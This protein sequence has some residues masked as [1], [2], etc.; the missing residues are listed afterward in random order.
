[1][2][3]TRRALLTGA[4]VLPAVGLG[5]RDVRAEAAPVCA[6]EGRAL[7]GYDPVAYFAD[8]RARPGNGAFALRWR[9]ATWLFAEEEHLEDFMMNP[10]AFA[11]RYG[12]YCALGLSQ[13]ALRVGDPE[14]WVIHDGRLYLIH[15]AP[16]LVL[17]KQD[18]AGNLRAADSNW[19]GILAAAQG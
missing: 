1:M 5:A 17:W 13:G 11:P 7:R 15:S 8:G 3:M 9:G 10:H 4:A 2:M 19:P 18:I 6:Q 16:E 14:A 12:G